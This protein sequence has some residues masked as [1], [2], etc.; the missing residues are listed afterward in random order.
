MFHELSDF[1]L[2]SKFSANCAL[3]LIDAYEE[4]LYKND[5]EHE[6]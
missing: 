6:K 2:V 4:I 3:V 5:V 1:Q